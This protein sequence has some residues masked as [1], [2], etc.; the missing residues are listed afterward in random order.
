[1]RFVSNFRNARHL[2]SIDLRDERID[3]VS[4]LFCNPVL[5]MGGGGGRG[6]VIGFYRIGRG[7]LTHAIQ[8]RCREQLVLLFYIAS[9]K[10]IARAITKKKKNATRFS[11]ANG[12][13]LR[14]AYTSDE[15][16]ATRFSSGGH[17][18]RF[19]IF[20]SLSHSSLL[21]LRPRLFLDWFAQWQTV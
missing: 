8:I 17:R 5:H 14:H 18:L 16:R 7:I 1:M 13:R 20:Q 4:L 15:Q 19:S 3:I 2:E 9:R 21:T 12:T 6:E 10:N 11:R